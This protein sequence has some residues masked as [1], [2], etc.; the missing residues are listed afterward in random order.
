MIIS[1]NTT[2]AISA[3][4]PNTK[5]EPSRSNPTCVMLPETDMQKHRHTDTETHRHTHTH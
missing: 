3:A 1:S 5:F 4:A 2:K